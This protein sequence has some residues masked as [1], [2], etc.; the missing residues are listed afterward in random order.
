VFEFT[1]LA[2]AAFAKFVVV[3]VSAA[4]ATIPV[5]RTVVVFVIAVRVAFVNGF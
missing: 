4:I 5:T 3:L 1:V 2:V